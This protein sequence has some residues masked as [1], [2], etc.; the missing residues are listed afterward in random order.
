M[1]S[2]SD[3][4][5]QQP[6]LLILKSPLSLR[7]GGK[8][9]ERSWAS[10]S[11][12]KGRVLVEHCKQVSSC[13]PR[14]TQTHTVPETSTYWRRWLERGCISGS[15]RNW[16]KRNSHR[17][18]RMTPA[19]TPSDSGYRAWIGHL[20]WSDW[21][22]PQLLSESL[23]LVTD[24]NRCRYPQPNIRPTLGNPDKERK[25]CRGQRDQGHHKTAHRNNS[26][27]SK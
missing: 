3:S 9:E 12:E 24:G 11:H 5:I 19:K 6:L 14:A 21:W 16:Y 15:G 26:L 7:V 4:E 8:N 22:L 10:Q 1:C 13:S 18:P 23:H 20:L 2:F 27:D 25:D 17:S